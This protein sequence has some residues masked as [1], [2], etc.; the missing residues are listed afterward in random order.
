[1]TKVAI[2]AFFFFDED[3]T[4]VNHLIYTYFLNK[5]KTQQSS[6]FFFCSIWQNLAA[7]SGSGCLSVVFLKVN[8]YPQKR[9]PIPISNQ[10]CTSFFLRIWFVLK[11]NERIAKFGLHHL[12]YLTLRKNRH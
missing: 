10:F 9:F 12:F 11:L 7:A 2:L 5:K 8:K 6:F 1:V 3:Q 4:A